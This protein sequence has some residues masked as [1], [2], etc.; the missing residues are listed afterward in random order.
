[1]SNSDQRLDEIILRLDRIEKAL[2]IVPNRDGIIKD[3]ESSVS[4]YEIFAKTELN[5]SQDTIDNQKSI[6]LRFLDDCYGII[7]K[8]TVTQYLDSNESESWKSNQ[9]KALRRYIRDFLKLGN[10]INEFEFSKTKA[11]IKSIPTDNQIVRFYEFLPRQIQV[12]FLILMTSGL[13]LNEVLSLR[14]LDVSLET[15]MVNTTEIHK[16]ST[17]SS[18]ISFITRQASE[19]LEDWLMTSDCDHEGEE[20]HKIFCISDRTVQQAFKQASETLGISINPHL[21]RTIFTEKYNQAGIKDKY[22]DAFCGR[23]SHTVLA[24]HYTDYS[25]DAL[26]KQYDLVEPLLI[27]RSI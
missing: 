17:K 8:E 11:K 3:F 13:R 6:I 14:I 20:N 5:L 7:N 10:W 2:N 12:I 26:R 1:M 24:K 15:G 18:W 23:V 9:V 19:V 21:L 4:D 22:I 16:G 27:L 25:P